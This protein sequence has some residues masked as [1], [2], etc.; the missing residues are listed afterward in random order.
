M[1][2]ADIA[3]PCP[4]LETKI[5]TVSQPS[6]RAASRVFPNPPEVGRWRPILFVLPGMAEILTAEHIVRDIIS[7]TSEDRKE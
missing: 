2:V 5:W 1:C 3:Q 6:S 4:G 7:R